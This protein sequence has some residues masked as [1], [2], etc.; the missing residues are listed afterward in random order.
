MAALLSALSSNSPVVQ[1]VQQQALIWSDQVAT[2][3]QLFQ[4]RV[5]SLTEVEDSSLAPVAVTYSTS[6]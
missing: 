5:A 3:Q 6:I 2:D 4:A 1:A